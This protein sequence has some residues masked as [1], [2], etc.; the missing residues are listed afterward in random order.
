MTGRCAAG[1]VIAIHFRKLRE[2]LCDGFLLSFENLGFFDAAVEGN[3]SRDLVLG[4]GLPLHMGTEGLVAGIVYR[5]LV[6]GRTGIDQVE[7][8]FGPAVS[9]LVTGVQ[10]MSAISDLNIDRDAPVLGQ[11]DAQKD[12]IRK[13]LIALVDDVRVALIKLAE[14]TCAI[15]AVKEDMDTRLSVA[16][17]VFDVY[18]PL[19]HRLGIGHLKWELEDLSFRYLYQDAYHKIAKLLD[20]KRVEVSVAPLCG[21]AGGCPTL[22]SPFG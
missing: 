3:R 12:N 14:R 7:E 20:G 9:R 4:I 5:A 1:D 22:T 21:C 2:N 15:R 11:A 17:E 19:A 13:M 6:E 10:R 16:R 18:A 8:K